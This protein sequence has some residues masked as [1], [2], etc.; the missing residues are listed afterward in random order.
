M[1]T[2][3]IKIESNYSFYTVVIHSISKSSRLQIV[4][5]ATVVML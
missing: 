1:E 3:Y 5:K 2:M 4:A